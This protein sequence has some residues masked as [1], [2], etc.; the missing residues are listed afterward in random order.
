MQSVQS[1]C[2]HMSKWDPAYKLIIN[3]DETN[4]YITNNLQN[5]ELSICCKEPYIEGTVNAVSLLT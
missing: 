4:A 5:C 2:S 3:L 1:S